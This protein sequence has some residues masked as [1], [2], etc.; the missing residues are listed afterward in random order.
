MCGHGVFS[1]IYS[2]SLNMR[3]DA[4]VTPEMREAG[5]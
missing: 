2:L 1:P 4:E 5:I 3:T